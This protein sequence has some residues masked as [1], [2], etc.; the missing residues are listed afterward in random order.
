MI[1]PLKTKENQNSKLDQA[2]YLDQYIQLVLESLYILTGSKNIFF[3]I[4]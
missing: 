1:W 2:H 3:L 4:Q